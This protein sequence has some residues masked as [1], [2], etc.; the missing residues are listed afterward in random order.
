MKFSTKSRYALRL[1]AELARY[2]QEE[3][4]PL[5]TACMDAP[6]T[7]GSRALKS[8]ARF[9]ELMMNLTLTAETMNAD[10]FEAVYN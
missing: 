7:L 5:L 4:I 6:Q 10:Q 2:A 9:S 3:G 1:M 8:V